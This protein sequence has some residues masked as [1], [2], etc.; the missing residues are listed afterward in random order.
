MMGDNKQPATQ[1]AAPPPAGD[2]ATPR[3]RRSRRRLLGWIAGIFL[4]LLA[5]LAALLW[6]RTPNGAPPR[7]NDQIAVEPQTSVIAVPI[8]ASLRDLAGALEREVPRALWS[9]DQPDQVCIPSKKVKVIF[10]KIRTPT[11]KCR[12]V[13]QVTRGP[14]T[15]AGRGQD[16]VVTMPIHAVVMARDI[17]GI[18]KQE[19]ATA[20]ARVRAVVRLDLTSD[21][22]PKG[23]IDIAY[24][25][26]D[27]PHIDFLGR[28]IELTSQADAKLKGVVA[29]LEQTLPRQLAKL[30]LRERAAQAWRSAFTSLDINAANPPVWMRITPRALSYGGYAIA[31]DRLTV[32]IGMTA[33]TE[34]FVG[35]RP[36][37]PAPIPLP[38]LRK[39]ARQAGYVQFAIPVVAD[40]AELEP[41]LAKALVKRSARPFNV[42]GIGAVN[43]QFGKVTIYGTTGGKIAVGLTFTAA[44]PGG[45]PS[46]GTVWLTAT[47]LNGVNSRRVAFTDLTVAGVTD[48]T[49]TGLLIRLANAPVLVDTIAQSLTQ[50]FTKDYDRLLAKVSTALA[51]KRLGAFTIRSHITDVQTGRLRATGQGIYLSVV[52]K[53]TAAITLDR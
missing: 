52:G 14:M 27:A 44:T 20:D 50:N 38:P 36:P 47:P 11:I 21:W 22:T 8:T 53:G 32:N 43:A 1:A 45:S 34:T 12:I 13:G 15:I 31:G 17:G 25:W 9:I 41:V 51:E 3:R 28:R 46:R 6:W 2:D 7:A 5:G 19:T 37:D 24:D 10:V 16:I 40:Y 30:G 35:P 23:R 42:P 49:G 4:A 33:L 48:S 39:E 26:T 18:L 29:K